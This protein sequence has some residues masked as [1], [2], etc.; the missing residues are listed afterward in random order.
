MGTLKIIIS[1]STL[2][3]FYIKVTKFNDTLNL[4]ILYIGKINTYKFSD[5]INL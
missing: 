3:I 4:A 2:F 1:E 5:F